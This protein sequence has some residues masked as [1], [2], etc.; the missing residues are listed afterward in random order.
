MDERVMKLAWELVEYQNSIVSRLKPDS[1][2]VDD[3]FE[4]RQ[5]TAEF[6][7]KIIEQSLRGQGILPK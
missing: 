2:S 1:A 3:I 4:A 5:R 6:I 7:A